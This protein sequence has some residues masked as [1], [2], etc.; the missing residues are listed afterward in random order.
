MYLTS[1]LC[2]SGKKT[3]VELNAVILSG[4]VLLTLAR[5]KSLCMQFG[6]RGQNG[7]TLDKFYF[8]V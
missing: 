1:C 7:V 5:T 3:K 6:I 4:M 2:L 8:W